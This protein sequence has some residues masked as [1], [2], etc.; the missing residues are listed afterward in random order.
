CT[1]CTFPMH[2]IELA[3]HDDLRADS[4]LGEFECLGCRAILKLPVD[5]THA[6]E[7]G[8]FRERLQQV[9]PWAATRCP[10]LIT[11][12]ADA[13]PT[14]AALWPEVERGDMVRLLQSPLNDVRVAAVT[15]SQFLRS[16]GTS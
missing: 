2:S 9:V 10:D 7:A 4:H 13:A 12:I 11:A 14:A 5:V 3:D 6:P 8:A 1:L 16:E 15:L